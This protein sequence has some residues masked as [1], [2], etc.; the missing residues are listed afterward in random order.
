MQHYMIINGKITHFLRPPNF[1]NNN[2]PPGGRRKAQ[3]T[4]GV[5]YDLRTFPGLKQSR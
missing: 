5:E 1:R 2:S 3:N 4:D